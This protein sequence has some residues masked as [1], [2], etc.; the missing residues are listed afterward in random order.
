VVVLR[1]LV[2]L[3]VARAAHGYEGTGRDRKTLG[4]QSR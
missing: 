3:R 2:A 1:V 4:S